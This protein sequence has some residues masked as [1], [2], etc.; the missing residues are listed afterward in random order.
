MTHVLPRQ[1]TYSQRQ[2]ARG[3]CS[4]G[5]CEIPCK[6]LNWKWLVFLK[7]DSNNNKYSRLG[8][9]EIYINKVGIS[10]ARSL[11]REG[12]SKD[13]QNSKK[14]TILVQRYF[15]GFFGE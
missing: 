4:D 12:S 2:G 6:T 9:R 13:F 3:I 11:M 7:R 15:F 10:H 8:F 5:N 1:T 14:H